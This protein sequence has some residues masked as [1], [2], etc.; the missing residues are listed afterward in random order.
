M[1][2]ACHYCIC[3]FHLESFLALGPLKNL[4]L[5]MFLGGIRSNCD[6]KKEVINLMMITYTSFCDGRVVE[7]SYPISKKHIYGSHRQ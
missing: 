7:T 4:L 6:L 5:Q 3:T 1:L 2:N